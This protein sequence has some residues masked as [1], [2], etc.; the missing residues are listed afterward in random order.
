V[1]LE[2]GYV[3]QS[4]LNRDVMAFAGV[5]PTAIALAPWL[6][7]DDIAWPARGHSFSR[8]STTFSA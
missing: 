4:H 5:T 7:V 1:A 2:S 6:A 8:T 3:D